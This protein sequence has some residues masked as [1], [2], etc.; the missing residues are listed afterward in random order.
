MP[1]VPMQGDFSKVLNYIL[2]E[3]KM[4]WLFY[5]VRQLN[6]QKMLDT[7]FIFSQPKKR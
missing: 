7:Y 3:F 1:D 2:G 4:N 5:L 6:E